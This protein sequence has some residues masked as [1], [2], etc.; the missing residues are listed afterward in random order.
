M[1]TRAPCLVVVALV[2]AAPGAWPVRAQEP[3]IRALWVDSF[4]PGLR[5]PADIDEL[6]ARVKRGNL[7]TIIAQV[8]RNAQSLFANA[9]EG[10]VENYLPPDGFDPLQDLIDKAHREGIEVHGWVN[11]GPIYSGHPLVPTASWPCGVP[12]DPD[13]V[14]NR[15]GW[16][17]PD[18]N[19]WLT[20]THPSFPEG[21]HAA[22]P[23]ER[24]SS[25]LWWLDL[26]HPNAA[27]YTIDVLLHLL[28]NYDVDGLHLDYIRYPEMPITAPPSGGLSFST[29]YNPVSAERFNAAHGRTPG[30]LPD[31]WDASW[32]E[33]RRDQ[34]R[35][36]VR[37]LYL[38][39]IAIRPHAKLSAALI[40]FF[41]GPNDVEPRTFAQ[42]EAYYRV[43]QDWNGWM[44]EGILDWA[45]PMIY[46]SHHLESHRVQFA[47]WTE[48][49]K[50]AQY[51][52]YGVI[53]LGAFMNSLEN[54][55]LQVDLGRAPALTGASTRGFNFFS[56]NATNDAIPG[57]PMQ[58]RDEFFRALAEDGAYP[59]SAPFSIPTPLP[60]MPREVWPHTGHLLAQILDADGQPA[61]G[62]L[63]TIREVRARRRNTTIVQYADGNGYVSGV[64]LSPGRYQL[65]ITHSDGVRERV[66]V[67]E[68]V[69]ASHVTTAQ[70]YL[71]HRSFGPVT[72]EDLQPLGARPRVADEARSRPRAE[73]LP[74][75][76]ALE[77]WQVHEPLPEDI[78]VERARRPPR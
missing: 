19:Y 5:S 75:A 73:P 49:T 27:Q 16:G 47:E 74:D 31:P 54:T 18:E 37:R 41:R 48:F 24:L 33:W 58:P 7:N 50:N 17:Q 76:S 43:F 71:R 23:G 1:H 44:R 61:D 60:P 45:I 42:T 8:R 70:I 2:A 40:T 78:Q 32:S 39:T 11:I 56:Y 26:G 77:E 64:D 59:Q 62:V 72:R 63:V 20:R 51:Q 34:V 36:F 53:G 66:N 67:T 15:H 14:F 29:G 3:E 12:C 65:L 13:H 21:T 35:A 38:E 46:K 10:W 6:I 9:L 69:R 55:I 25:G 4:N 57:Q 52:R 28:R 22:F 68:R 30:T